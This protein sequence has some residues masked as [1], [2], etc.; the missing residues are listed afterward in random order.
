MKSLCQEEWQA[1]ETVLKLLSEL[2]YSVRE[3]LGALGLGPNDVAKVRTLTAW[4]DAQS[5]PAALDDVS[6]RFRIGAKRAGER[7]GSSGTPI[8]E[9][10]GWTILV[11]TT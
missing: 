5:T 4:P 6:P 3:R 7:G 9:M 1:R 2:D 8:G 10:N 11:W